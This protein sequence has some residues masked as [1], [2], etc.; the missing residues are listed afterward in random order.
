MITEPAWT[1]PRRNRWLVSGLVLLCLTG[2]WYFRQNWI[3]VVLD[4]SSPLLSRVGS[5]SES[6]REHLQPDLLSQ[7]AQMLQLESENELL[8]KQLAALTI[9]AQ[10]N[11][12]LR[13]LL[14]LPM[15]TGFTKL[16]VRVILRP[17][18]HWFETLHLDRGFEDGVSLNQVVMNPTGVVGKISEVTAHTSQ[19]QLI[20]HPDSS[21]ACIVGEKKVP[22]VLTGRYRQQD[23]Q[24]QY[25]QNYAQIGAGDTVLTSGLGGV[26]PPNLVLGV[27]ETVTKQPERPVPD[28]GVRL[29][30]LEQPLE[31][32]VVLVPES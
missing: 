7:P 9:V 21:V 31:H 27:V 24:L 4:T 10:E 18:H 25:L 32:L 6:L 20:S 8:K 3:P 26:Y 1:P 5:W 19:V 22:G 16:S 13:E 29:S 14:K 15:P 2:I 17:P 12:E 11:Q 28:A 30:P 23:A